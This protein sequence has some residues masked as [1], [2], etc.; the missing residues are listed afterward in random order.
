[1]A[2]PAR[3]FISHVF[4]SAPEVVFDKLSDHDNL[5]PVLGAT[6]TRLRDG[7]TERNG[8]GSARTV[9]VGPL[10][11]FVETTTTAE[12]PSLIEYRITEGSPL[13]GHW[14]RQELTATPDGGTRLD[15]SIGFNAVVPG[16]AP[17]VAAALQRVIGKGIGTLCP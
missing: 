17:L 11:G 14:G 2:A 10:P 8:V 5:G 6:I 3:V 15:Y 12:R 16:L 7:D 13:R 4:T 1:M 9:K